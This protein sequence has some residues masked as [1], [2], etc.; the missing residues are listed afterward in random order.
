MQQAKMGQVQQQSPSLAPA[1][2]VA[3]TANTQDATNLANA[4]QNNVAAAS[5]TNTAGITPNGMMSPNM[6]PAMANPLR[7]QEALQVRQ[8]TAIAA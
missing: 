1:G 2:L 8:C 5:N 4:V 7:Q 3:G 6:T